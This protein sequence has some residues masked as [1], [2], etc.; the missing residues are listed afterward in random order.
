[1]ASEQNARGFELSVSRVCQQARN[2]RSK[3][4]LRQ[5]RKLQEA[6]VQPLQLAFRHRVEVDPTNAF[7]GTRALQPTQQDLGG[8]G[9]GDCALSQ[10]TF[11]LRVTG[12]FTDTAGSRREG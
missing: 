3:F 1:M 11:D 10:T 5:G 7:L 4:H 9:I 8:T 6:G 2:Q 12:E